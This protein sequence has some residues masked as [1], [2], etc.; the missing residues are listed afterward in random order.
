MAGHELKSLNAFASGGM[1]L[2]LNFA[3]MCLIDY[4]GH[5]LIASSLLPISKDTLVYGSSD[6]GRTVR[7]DV[8]ELNQLMEKVAQILN[9]KGNLI[10]FVFSIRF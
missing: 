6:G 3:L 8:P 9:L 5:R 4:R 10:C 1:I 7:A 2:G